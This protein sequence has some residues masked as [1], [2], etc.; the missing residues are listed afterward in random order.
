MESFGE[1]FVYPSDEW[2]IVAD[3]PMP[4]AD[5]YDD[6]QLHENGLGMVPRFLDNWTGEQAEIEAALNG[7]TPPYRASSMTLVTGALFGGILADCARRFSQL[8]GVPVEVL[9]AANVR[10]GESITAAGLLMGGDVL[11]QLHEISLGEM[12]VLP[13]VMF[14][15]PDVIALDDIS[16]QDMANALK[17]PVA[18]ADTMGDVWD[19]LIGESQVVYMPAG[20]GGQP[21]SLRV[22]PPD[23]NGSA[24][25]L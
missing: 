14:D 16:P 5:Y 6:H 25:P 12:V 24:H 7:D 22:L 13:R 23:G 8:T 4:A 15:H 18:L 20:D 17:R 11:S 10:L 1:R 3:R 21:H 9:P 2:F 19:A